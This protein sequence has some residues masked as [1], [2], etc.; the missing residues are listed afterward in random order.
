MKKKF[1]E[2]QVALK[3]EYIIS[4]IKKY[5]QYKDTILSNINRLI[6]KK[7]PVS[8]DKEFKLQEEYINRL[9]KLSVLENNY[10]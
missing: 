9:L 6:E 7:M 5:T 3:N 1:H 8:N 4:E 2:K 10:H